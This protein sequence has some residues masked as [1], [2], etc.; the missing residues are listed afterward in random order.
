M[1]NWLFALI[2]LP[3]LFSSAVQAQDLLPF[4]SGEELRY[5]ISY[6]SGLDL[7]EAT[8]SARKSDASGDQPEQWNFLFDLEA[9]IP[10]F[11]VS[12]HVKS[13][14]TMDLCSVQLR[15]EISHGKRSGVE[16]TRFDQASGTAIRETLKGG[17]KSELT[18]PECA[19]DALT[20]L[21]YLRAEL[22][23]GRV[24][25]PRQV[26]FGAPYDVSFQPASTKKAVIGDEELET[27]RLIVTVKGPVSETMFIMLV[28]RDPAR[29]PVQVTV[30]LEP[31][32]FTMELVRE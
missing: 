10:G 2:L 18:I 17:G 7:G 6:P 27:D 28:A 15:K 8:L 31:G 13:I 24:P 30:P 20:F 5:V 16:E 11:S 32:N 19:T 23:R 9:A 21:Y 3:L 26:F 1:W 4:A 12:D 22:S 29:T 25:P 14:A